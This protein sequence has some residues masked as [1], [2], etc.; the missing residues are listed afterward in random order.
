LFSFYI[1]FKNLN[2]YKGREFSRKIKINK[3]IFCIKTLIIKSLI[4]K[5]DYLCSVSVG[6]FGGNKR[7]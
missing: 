7:I 5:K 2:S 1:K 6:N 4:Q 3:P